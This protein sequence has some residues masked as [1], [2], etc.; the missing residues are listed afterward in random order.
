MDE[1]TFST[2]F[3]PF[4]ASRNAGS[5][6]PS[7]NYKVEML[8]RGR[9]VVTFDYGQGCAH[10]PAYRREDWGGPGRSSARFAMAAR[11]RATRAEC[12]TGIIHAPAGNQAGYAPTGRKIPPPK[13]EDILSCVLLDCTALHS[14]SFEDWAADYGFD[15]D[16]RKAEAIYTDS[17][18]FALKIRAALGGELLSTLQEQFQDY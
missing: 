8:Y 17:I 14:A 3:V 11:D 4:A 10:C 5:S 18:A 2:T 13:K 12:E 15:A 7:L 9:S 1:I 16:S 6:S